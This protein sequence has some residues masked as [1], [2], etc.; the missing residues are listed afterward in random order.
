MTQTAGRAA[1]NLNGMVIMYADEI[2]RSM[3]NTIDE[4][5]RRR[6]KQLKYNEEHGITPTQIQKSTEQILKQTTVAGK[7]A[8][9]DQQ[10][11]YVEKQGLAIAADPLIKYMS[12]QELV[13]VRDT[14]RRNMEKAAKELDFMEAARLRDEMN[15][16]NKM[17][18]ETPES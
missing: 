14:T 15:V 8:K 4:T 13:K 2:T 18:E 5:N 3:K 12:R 9:R 7:R 6:E 10:D 17:I 16:L 1:R 11:A